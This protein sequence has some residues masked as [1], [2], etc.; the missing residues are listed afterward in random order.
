MPPE[1]TTSSAAG[2]A[3]ACVRMVLILSAAGNDNED[4][5]A[6]T[7]RNAAAAEA[8]CEACAAVHM[9]LTYDF[10]RRKLLAFINGARGRR[11][12]HLN[13]G[14]RGEDGAEAATR[15]ILVDTTYHRFG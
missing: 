12:R 10:A 9:V 11:W 8:V 1:G 13:S 14:G 5:N 4:A 15:V 7:D 2:D 3:D 6:T